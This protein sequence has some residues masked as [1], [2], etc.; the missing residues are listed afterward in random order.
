MVYVYKCSFYDKPECKRCMLCRS[1]GLD[2]NGET[3]ISC[4]ALGT[5]RQCTNP[6]EELKAYRV[7]GC[8]TT[9][10]LIATALL[11]YGVLHEFADIV[12][13][14][15]IE[16]TDSIQ[17]DIEVTLRKW[18]FDESVIEDLQKNGQDIDKVY[19]SDSKTNLQEKG[20]DI[21]KFFD[22]DHYSYY[23]IESDNLN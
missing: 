12:A 1:R 7:A 21:M 10:G 5:M 17:E 13:E 9:A 23:L 4:S 2:G 18:G 6:R 19:V 16:L 15:T 11:G 20:Y 14:P 3:V 22:D 8:I